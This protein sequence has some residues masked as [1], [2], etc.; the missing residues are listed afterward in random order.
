[1]TAA[2]LLPTL[3]EVREHRPL[4]LLSARIEIPESCVCGGVG[5]CLRCVLD[6]EAHDKRLLDR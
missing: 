3:A 4:P 6:D 1:M 2:V 5:T